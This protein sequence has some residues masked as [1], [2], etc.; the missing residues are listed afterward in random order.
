MTTLH[1]VPTLMRLEEKLF[2]GLS[3]RERK[4]QV[5]KHPFSMIDGSLGDA[6]TAS[7][8]YHITG[9]D[10][11]WKLLLEQ[12]GTLAS[13]LRSVRFDE[14]G[15]LGG[16]SGMAFV[17]Q[18]SRRSEEDFSNALAG[19]N[20]RIHYLVDKKL[21]NLRSEVSKRRQDYDYAVGVTGI[22]YWAFFMGG[23]HL[24]LAE[25]ICRQLV[26]LVQEELPGCFWTAASDLEPDLLVQLPETNKGLRDLGFAH[27]I[28]GVIRLL[29]L[30]SETFNDASFET[31]ADK[32]FSVLLND[33]AFY[34]GTGVSFFETPLAAGEPKNP[35]HKSRQ[36]WCY[37]LPSVELAAFGSQHRQQCLDQVLNLQ[38][39]YL[40]PQQ[41]FFDETGICHGIAGR[42]YL[43][44]QLGSL[45]GEYWKTDLHSQI[46][47]FLDLPCSE[48]D[49]SFW[50]G[51]G[52]S[53]SVWAG[54]HDDKNYAPALAILGI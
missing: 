29:Q 15:L 17:L 26:D 39:D 10:K 45:C 7:C 1:E 14:G 9:D 50:H 23:K 25:K 32:L 37:G 33:I 52:G 42:Q 49:L 36:A 54:M 44:D 5:T 51:I 13:Y 19:L 35:S 41:G 3:S 46:H 4:D 2:I 11:W 40:D 6:Y 27:G 16:L 8:F 48:S 12:T 47:A 30:A 31:A 34:S 24:A 28:C 38:E 22:A 20:T 21:W 43:A 18:A 53:A